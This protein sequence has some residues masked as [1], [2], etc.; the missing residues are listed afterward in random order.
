[1]KADRNCELKSTC[2]Q[3]T[4]EMLFRS[5]EIKDGQEP[6]C[7]FTFLSDK[8]SRVRSFLGKL[9]VKNID[10][11]SSHIESVKESRLFFNFRW[12]HSQPLLQW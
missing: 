3:Y 11:V 7:Q 5:Q 9:F 4:F 1:M 6:T 10:D 12:Y 8:D 2:Q